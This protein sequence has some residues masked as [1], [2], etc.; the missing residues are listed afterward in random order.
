MARISS[1]SLSR[2]ATFYAGIFP[3]AVSSSIQKM[4][5]SASSSNDAEF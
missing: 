4:D 5:S 2:L 1:V 3:A